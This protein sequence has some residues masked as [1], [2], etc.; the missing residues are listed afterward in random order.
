M[1]FNCIKC[2]S[3]LLTAKLIINQT[4]VKFIILCFKYQENWVWSS[5]V[6]MCQSSKIFTICFQTISI[7]IKLFCF[8]LFW[9]SF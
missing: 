6:K 3:I 5:I 9:I 8:N 7:N 2:L 4:L 1:F